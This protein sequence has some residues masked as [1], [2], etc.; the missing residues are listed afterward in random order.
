MAR[1]SELNARFHQTLCEPCDNPE[2]LGMISDLR[3]RVGPVLARLVTEASGR[4]RPLAEHEQILA[5]CEARDAGRA[6]ALLRGHIEAT[7]KETAAHLRRRAS[8]GP[9]AV[10]SLEKGTGR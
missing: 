1:W 6:V 7:K 10:R 3:H 2:L 9:G 5:A 4:D 8:G